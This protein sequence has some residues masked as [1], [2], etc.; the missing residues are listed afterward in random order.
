MLPPVFMS[1]ANPHK[2]RDDGERTSFDGCEN[3]VLDESQFAENTVRG[4]RT[5]GTLGT[6]ALGAAVHFGEIGLV[7]SD[8]AMR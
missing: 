5:D 3:A 8:L 7:E 2:H 1:V 6:V 4:I